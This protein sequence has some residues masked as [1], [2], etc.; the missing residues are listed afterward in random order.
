MTTTVIEIEWKYDVD[1]DALLPD[2]VGLPDG[3]QVDPQGTLA[4]S[5]TYYD[6]AELDLIRAG[7]TLRRRTG[8]DDAGWHL[9]LPVGTDRHELQVPLEGPAVEPPLELT[10]IVRG[11]VRE[12]PLV[13]VG[14]V[15]TSRVSTL[16]RAVDGRLLAEVCDDRVTARR[17]ASGSSE[18]ETWREWE[19][20]FNGEPDR[21]VD[22]LERRLLAAGAR[23]SARRAKLARILPVTA[24]AAI[25]ATAAKAK[26][27]TV[28]EVLAPYLARQVAEMTRLDPLVRADV[29]DAVHSM[30]V[31]GRRVRA[32]LGTYRDVF[33][34]KRTGPLRVEVK[35]LVDELGRPRDLEVLRDR[36]EVLLAGNALSVGSVI[37]AEHRVAHRAAVEAMM[38]PRYFALVDSLR[39]LA[40]E[41]PWSAR[42]GRPARKQLRTALLEDFRR[43]ERAT[44][45]ARRGTDVHERASR[46]HDVRKAAKRIRYSAE[47]VVPVFGADARR[48]AGTLAELQDVL[49]G[50]HDTA[51]ARLELLRLAEQYPDL[52]LSAVLPDL[53]AATAADEHAYERTV[54]RLF[55]PKSRRW[56]R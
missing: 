28:T 40:E 3:V 9:K 48:L 2:L 14:A 44:E 31:A 39:A 22:E 19:V 41:P 18:A 33:D 17:I 34:R 45:K 35:W 10:A 23:P 21:M 49:G 32:V 43:L 6:T 8:G 7:I 26:K 20:E 36:L 25:G 13:R 24:P 55:R 42:A 11:V 50:H 30:R 12:R 29:P 53:D 38:S 27:A 4:L 1:E 52:A 47:A 46:L 56:L 51:V 15:D 54:S 5:A 16:L 37:E